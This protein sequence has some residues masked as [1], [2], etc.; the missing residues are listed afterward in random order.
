FAG[1]LRYLSA[2]TDLDA[3][4]RLEFLCGYLMPLSDAL[5]RIPGL[6]SQSAGAIIK[7]FSGG[8]R[9]LF[10]GSGFYADYYAP[11]AIAKSNAAKVALGRK[12]FSD[13]RLSRSGTVSCRSCHQPERYFTDGLAKAGGFVH[14]GAPSRNTPTLLYAALQSH[15]FY[16]LRSVSLEDQADQVMSSRS[17]F[18]CPADVIAGKIAAD[19]TYLLLFR[20]AFGSDSLDGYKVRNALAAFV[21]SL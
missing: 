5:A 9:A 20:P 11:Y 1:A 21:R 7:P 19:K 16:D 3:F 6:A 15:Q 10:N 8:L 4:D 18:D 2:H 12:L 13:T 17:E 14:G